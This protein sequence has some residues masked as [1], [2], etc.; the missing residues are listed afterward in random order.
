M[1]LKYPVPNPLNFFYQRLLALEDEG[2]SQGL[3]NAIDFYGQNIYATVLKPNTNIGRVY[4]DYTTENGFD[5][6]LAYYLSARAENIVLN[7]ANNYEINP[8][9]NPASFTVLAVSDTFGV[10][11]GDVISEI[12]IPANG[13]YKLTMYTTFTAPDVDLCNVPNRYRGMGK[14][15]PA[16]WKYVGASFTYIYNS[17]YFTH[18]QCTDFI[19]PTFGNTGVAQMRRLGGFMSG[20]KL[21]VSIPSGGTG[22]FTLNG[23]LVVTVSSIEFAIERV[24]SF[25]EGFE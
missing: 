14:V 19:T 16:F 3:I 17:T 20:N 18:V 10:N 25:L 8:A 12:T 5:D 2:S 4:I 13:T 15:T 23:S 24:S 7:E 1:P 6:T 21:K 22:A 11:V 9:V